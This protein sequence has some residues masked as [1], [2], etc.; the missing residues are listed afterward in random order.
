VG[1]QLVCFLPE[2]GPCGPI[3]SPFCYTSGVPSFLGPGVTQR[4][5]GCRL[6]LFIN[7]TLAQPLMLLD[8]TECGL[9]VVV[10]DGGCL[11]WSVAWTVFFP[12]R[13]RGCPST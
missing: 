2:D 3:L 9:G 13:F 4:G 10:R 6:C 12:D 5:L 11:L 7:S 1:V 8:E